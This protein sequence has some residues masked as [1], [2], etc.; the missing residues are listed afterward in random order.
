MEFYQ[1]DGKT[2]S[3]KGFPDGSVEFYRE[4]GKTLRKKI[5][6]DDN[7]IT[8]DEKGKNPFMISYD[9]FKKLLDLGLDQDAILKIRNKDDLEKAL[10]SQPTNNNET[11]TK[12]NESQEG[13]KQPQEREKQ[14][15]EGEKKPQGNNSS[16]PIRIIEDNGEEKQPEQEDVSWIA[17]KAQYYEA[18]AQGGKIQD[19]EQDK[20][21]TNVFCAKFNNSTITYSSPD[22]VT[23]SK[24]AD[25]KAFDSICKDPDNKGRPVEFPANQSEAFY[26]KMYAACALNGNPMV[27]NI[28]EKINFEELNNCG[29]TPEQ[30][31]QVKDVYNKQHQQEAEKPE[32]KNEELK[33]QIKEALNEQ[34]EFAN[35]GKKV[36]LTGQGNNAEVVAIN[37]GTNEDIARWK[38][39]KDKQEET[40]KFLAEQYRQNPDVV[41]EVMSEALK[42]KESENDFAERHNIRQVQRETIANSMTDEQKTA[43]QKEL[44]ERDKI[45]AARLGLRPEYTTK[46]KDGKMVTISKDEPTVTLMKNRYQKK[47]GGYD[48]YAAQLKSRS[49]R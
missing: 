16:T 23:V 20:T 34:V 4:D 6:K 33:K 37:G 26:A 40:K 30:I 7:R 24:D 10:N 5:D 3:L 38:E 49:E 12:K 42:E 45:M 22:E 9:D 25:F 36:S 1:E 46:D 44:S 35:L 28:P 27:G 8:F 31:Q 48:A 41:K 19:Y 2:L 39:L 47:E 18:L 43:R 32:Q 29:L 21:Q 11:N 15:Q 17:K 14:P 13:E